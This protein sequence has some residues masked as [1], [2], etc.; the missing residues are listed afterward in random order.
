MEAKIFFSVVVRRLFSYLKANCLIDISVQKVGL[1]GF[2]GLDH[3]MIWHQIQAARIEGR[4]L[5]VV[6]LDLAHAFRLVPHSLLWK[7]FCYF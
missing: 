7:A 1:P 5:S 2:G 4:D 6:F 3:S